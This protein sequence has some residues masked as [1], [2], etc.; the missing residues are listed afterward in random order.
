METEAKMADSN[1]MAV[2]PDW[3]RLCGRARHLVVPAQG[4]NLVVCDDCLVVASIADTYGNKHEVVRGAE[5]V[6]HHRPEHTEEK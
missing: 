2:N 6:Y 1:C 4:P 3:H 5:Q